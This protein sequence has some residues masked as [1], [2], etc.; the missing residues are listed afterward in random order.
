MTI[1]A[2]LDDVLGTRSN[3]RVL[4]TLHRLLPGIAI[5]GRDVGRRSGVSH[6]SATASLR[7]LTD[8]GLVR[9]RRA[10]R[11]DYY[12]MNRDHLL[13]ADL[14]SPAAAGGHR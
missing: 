5:S 7:T 8:L 9:V 14:G 12:E 4:R 6:P 1:G 11:V 2:L 10:R 3:V 13:A